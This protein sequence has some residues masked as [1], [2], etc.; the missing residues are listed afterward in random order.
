MG[1]ASEQL[2]PERV[3]APAFEALPDPQ[4]TPRARWREL[5]VRNRLSVSHA[6][7]DYEVAEQDLRLAVARQYPDISFGPGY[8]YDKGD[9]VVTLDAGPARAGPAQR[10]RADRAGARGAPQGGDAV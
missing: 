6:L 2:P 7:A 8:T 9:G 4:A 1:L 10:A 3:R 5:G